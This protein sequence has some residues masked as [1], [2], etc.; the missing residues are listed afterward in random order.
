MIS[1][2][3]CSKSKR[4]YK[5]AV[6]E[7]YIGNLFKKSLKYA[8]SL[9][10][11]KIYVLSAKYGLLSLYE[12]IEPYD[13]YLSDFSKKQ[14]FEWNVKVYNQIL[15][16]SIDFNDTALFLCG[17]LYYKD[18]KNLFKV[19]NCPLAHMGNGKQLQYLNSLIV[20]NNKKSLI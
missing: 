5:C 13:L 6:K 1:F 11:V 4:K 7:M 15:T 20:P 8:E 16:Q 2:L 14:L 3:G 19:A 12:I 10:N 17:S 18:I 9:E